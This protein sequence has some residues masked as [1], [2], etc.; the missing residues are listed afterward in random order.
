MIAI[1]VLVGLTA[2]QTLERITDNSAYNTIL[3][4]ML[5]EKLTNPV[6]PEL[7]WEYHDGLYCLSEKDADKLLDF[8]ENVL[9]HFLWEVDQYQRQCEVIISS[10]AE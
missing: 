3:V 10:L 4:S 8:A 7:N 2:C 9:P 5:P 6:W 1:L